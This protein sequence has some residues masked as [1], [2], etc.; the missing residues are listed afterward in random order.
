MALEGGAEA[1]TVGEYGGEELTFGTFKDV[2][3]DVWGGP[4]DLYRSPLR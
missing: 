4:S 3:S 2:G 1:G